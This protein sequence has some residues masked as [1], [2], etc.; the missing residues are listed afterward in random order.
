MP[1]RRQWFNAALVS[2]FVVGAAIRLWQYALNP[3]LWM[4]EAFLALNITERGFAQL[5]EPLAYNQAAPVGFLFAE[6]AAFVQFGN[7]EYAL[8]LFPLA[9]GLGALPLFWLVAR[10]AL[11]GPGL[12]VAVALFALSPEVIFHAVEVK[13]YSGDVFAALVAT[14]MGIR[15][16]ERTPPL[17]ESIV[18]GFLGAALLWTSHAAAFALGGVALCLLISATVRR[19][20]PR[21]L[22]L[23]PALGLWLANVLVLYLLALRNLT[24]HSYLLGYWRTSFPPF[25]PRSAVEF[26]WYRDAFVR[27]FAS[28]LGIDLNVTSG[29][30]LVGGG[31]ALAW[32]HRRMFWL[33]VAALL[34]VG[35]ASALH[36]YPF[37]GRLLVF[38][39]PAAIISLGAGVT[40]LWNDGRWVSRAAAVLL[41]L[42]LV[43]PQVAPVARNPARGRSNH[44]LRPVL[45]QVAAQRLPG[46][47]IHLYSMGWPAFTYYA[48]KFGL[49]NVPLTVSPSRDEG[50][51]S[52]QANLQKLAGSGR[53]W[54]V[55]SHIAAAKQR[56]DDR[57]F[58][59]QVLDGI[60]R[61][62]QGI[63]AD[64]AWAYL[65]QL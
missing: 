33:L 29:I 16:W 42:A 12:L 10:R 25:P 64:G 43:A 37:A 46:D 57:V 9:C 27:F 3:S 13:Q 6:R 18:Y 39:V 48:K 30:A 50:Q 56:Q 21:L 44:D 2:A 34:V 19:D 22:R 20:G 26:A 65:Y 11:S 5:A 4:D 63:E 58:S 45:Q 62:L 61:R 49:A 60:G 23:S 7:N 47:K 59:L 36:Q 15:L 38:L 52:L 17:V 31:L 24:H 53:V 28:P 40:T 1:T 32:L 54:I 41:A 8:R 35:V 51:A 14:W 55:F